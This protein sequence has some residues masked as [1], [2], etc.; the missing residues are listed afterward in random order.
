MSEAITLG[1]DGVFCRGRD[2]WRLE[3]WGHHPEAENGENVEGY[4]LT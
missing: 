1:V 4:S 2:E 3:E